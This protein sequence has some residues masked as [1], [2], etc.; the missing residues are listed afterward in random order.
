V[1]STGL[2][3]VDRKV[4]FLDTMGLGLEFGAHTN[5][6]NNVFRGIMERVYFVENSPG[7]FSP[8]PLPQ[9]R[10]FR[11]LKGFRD[12]VCAKLPFIPVWSEK[13][14]LDC[15]SG[16]KQ[17]R[18]EK[19]A[20][21]LVTKPITVKD[22]YVSTFVKFEKTN[23]TA[24]G[25]PAPRVI[26]PRNARY[27]FSLG[28]YI[29][30][31][32]HEVYRAI[33]R[34][35]G[36][37]V[38]AKG[39]NVV[40]RAAMIKRC[41]DDFT[42]P[43][44]IS[45]DL[46]R[47]DQHVSVDALEYEHGF[48]KKAFKGDKT[49]EEY[50]K[51]QLV[52]TGFARTK[53][54]GCI[55]YTNRGGRMSGDMNTALGNVIIVCALMYQYFKDILV[56][57][58]LVDDGDDSVVVVERKDL[59]KILST[60]KPWFLEFGFTLKIEGVHYEME[61]IDFCQSRPVFDGSRWIMCR[62]IHTTHCKDLMSPKR[63]TSEDEWRAQCTAVGLCGLALAG[64]L[65]VFRHFYKRLNLGG[66]P[67]VLDSG[68]YYCSIGLQ[69]VDSEPTDAAR[70]S[71]FKAFNVTPDEQRAIESLYDATPLQWY[72]APED[73]AYKTEPITAIL[74]RN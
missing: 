62:N 32:E 16:S 38:V 11:R 43:V 6:Q 14:F 17:K 57:A 28:L 70:V 68:M 27:C 10:A 40:E 19:A 4:T 21:S 20:A 18:Y 61:H 35:F 73:I 52:N 60:A 39:K 64:N 41:W 30:P 54:G 26:Q 56:R 50:L 12:R 8:P 37:P 22:A 59:A 63:L 74:T 36:A 2:G 49:L 51:W 33:D 71:F 48:Y 47:M 23:F 34:V 15:Y 42:D 46:K 58:G 67:A 1:I 44:A 69:V 65:P 45:F 25:D 24:K 5:S 13:E 66:K 3:V 9:N 53:D 29:K 72:G 55:K 7:E 31:L